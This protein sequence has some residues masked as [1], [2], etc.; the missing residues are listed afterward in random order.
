MSTKR[1]RVHPPYKTK[2]RVTNWAEYDRA[3]VE[4]SSLTFWISPEAIDGW[5]AK[6]SGRRGAQAKFSDLAHRDGSHRCDSSST[7]HSARPRDSCVPPLS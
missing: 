6:P 5:R 7:F 3:L 1:S 4:R 2:Y